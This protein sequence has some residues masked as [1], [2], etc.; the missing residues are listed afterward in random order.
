MYDWAFLCRFGNVCIHSV[1]AYGLAPFFRLSLVIEMYEWM[2]SL[3][4]SLENAAIWEK[5]LN[6]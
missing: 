5:T 3:A 1:W 2:L 6:E 4:C